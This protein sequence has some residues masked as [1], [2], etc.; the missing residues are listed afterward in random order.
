MT[1]GGPEPKARWVGN[2]LADFERDLTD[3][4]C[5]ER[6]TTAESA[7]TQGAYCRLEGSSRFRARRL[8]A[9]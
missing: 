7:S 5:Y 3:N 1:P 6:G 9:R 8:T 2:T 4:L